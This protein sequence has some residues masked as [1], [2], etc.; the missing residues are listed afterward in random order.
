MDD[1]KLKDLT[2][3]MGEAISAMQHL[4]ARA[5]ELNRELETVNQE[6]ERLY[7]VVH[8]SPEN[9]PENEELDDLPMT[10][11][12]QFLISFLKENPNSPRKDI[13]DSGILNLI[14]TYQLKLLLSSMKRKGLIM[15]DGGKRG[16]L[17]S[18]SK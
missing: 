10:D 4:E 16:A 3:L 5:E 7:E 15:N 13:D 18:V 1:K 6:I 11:P 14:D 17:W 2:K 9:L 8:M 12:E